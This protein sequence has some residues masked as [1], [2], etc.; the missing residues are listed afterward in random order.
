MLTSLSTLFS[1]TLVEGS[2]DAQVF[3]ILTLGS[4]A[5]TYQEGC[6]LN[7]GK[8]VCTLVGKNKATTFSTAVTVTQSLTGVSVVTASAGAKNGAGQVGAG[9]VG[10]AGASVLAGVAAAA[11]LAGAVM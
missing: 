6:G 9:W 2:T 7:N 10:A 11:M 4:E 5:F 8:A 3:Q 1:A